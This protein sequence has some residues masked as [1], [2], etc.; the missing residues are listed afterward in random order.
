VLPQQIT[1]WHLCKIYLLMLL[2]LTQFI[3]KFKWTLLKLLMIPTYGTKLERSSILCTTFSAL[4][5]LHL[6]ILKA[7][8]NFHKLRIMILLFQEVKMILIV[9]KLQ[10]SLT[11]YSHLKV[12]GTLLLALSILQ[13]QL[14]ILKLIFVEM[15]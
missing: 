14:T 1:E 9:I 13:M 3:N 5:F 8:M 2:T 11:H 6:K 7:L 4:I 12:C 15:K 10:L